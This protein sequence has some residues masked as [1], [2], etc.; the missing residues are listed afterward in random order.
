MVYL[1]EEFGLK[2]DFF[3]LKFILLCDYIWMNNCDVFFVVLF[4]NKDKKLICI[5]GIYVELG[6]VFVIGKF[7]ILLC[8]DNYKS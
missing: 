8:D 2:I 1:V 4:F 5:D 6:W 3:L 7:I